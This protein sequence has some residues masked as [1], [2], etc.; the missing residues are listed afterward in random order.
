MLE[1]VG[2]LP[3]RPVLV[4]VDSWTRYTLADENAAREVAAA[5]ENLAALCRD[6]DLAV[7]LIHHV[8]KGGPMDRSAPADRVRGSSDFLN[9]VSSALYF[10]RVEDV[11]R[12]EQIKARDGLPIQPVG[13]RI[14]PHASIPDRLAFVLEDAPTRAPSKI[15]QAK[16]AVLA[17]VREA[18]GSTV[19]DLERRGIAPRTTLWDAVH[20]LETAGKVSVREASK[21]GG[22]AKTL[23]PVCEQ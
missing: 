5:F 11:V 3:V 9:A 13:F 21:Q 17:A 1:I 16:A 15:E 4:V 6:G 19:G 10:S 18:P 7:A 8:R 20:E 2:R 14:R 23:Y 12:L 22:T